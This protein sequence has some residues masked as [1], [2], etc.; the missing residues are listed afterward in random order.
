MKL[1]RESISFERGQDPK[2]SMGIGKHR[3]DNTFV[4]MDITS[5]WED[6]ISNSYDQRKFLQNLSMGLFP[7]NF[8]V[9]GH[10]YG[11]DNWRDRIHISAHE[12]KEFEWV[13]FEEKYY[14]V[15]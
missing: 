15:G 4:I 10:R 7:A 6:T 5:G 13:E 12:L 2:K 1:V 11:T 3:W 14:P 8:E 9:Y